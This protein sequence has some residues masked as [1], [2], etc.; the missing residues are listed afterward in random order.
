MQQAYV[1]FNDIP[2]KINFDG[3][4]WHSTNGFL[5]YMKDENNETISG[6]DEII[7]HFQA[8]VH[9][10]SHSALNLFHV[11]TTVNQF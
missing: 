3:S 1:K 8:K 6:Y 2:V 10:A 9:F 4:P 7:S 5:P 11:F